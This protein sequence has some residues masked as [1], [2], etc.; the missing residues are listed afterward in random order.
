MNLQEKQASTNCDVVVVGGGPIG[1]EVAVAVQQANLRVVVLEKGCV[2]NTINWWAP[3]TRWF[4]SNERIAIAGVPLMTPDQTKATRE[5]YL[6]Y[7]LGIVRQFQLPIRTYEQ[8]TTICPAAHSDQENR[9]TVT[10]QRNGLRSEYHCQHVV[11]ATGGTDHPNPLGV[12]GEDL[13]HVDGFLREPHTYFGRRVLILGGRNSAIEAALRLFHAGAEVTLVYRGTGLPEDHI[14]YWLLPE[15]RSL[16][17]SGRINAHFGYVPLRITPNEVEFRAAGTRNADQPNLVVQ[18][19]SVLSLIGYYQDKSLFKETGI[20][21][22]GAYEQP[23]FDPETMETNIKGI[24]IAG[25]AT[26]GT[27]TSSYKI[28]LENC[29]VHVQRILHAITGQA[30]EQGSPDYLQQATLNP[31]S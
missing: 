27:Q 19:D 28:F 3:G 21:L 4:S 20:E 26:A 2:G 29:H 6:N 24:F 23:L 13:P 25:T 17:R 30:S 1:I 18:A 12:E 14:K 15:I 11:L 9:F 22:Q 8:V 16:I 10:T 7:L 31:E 5:Q